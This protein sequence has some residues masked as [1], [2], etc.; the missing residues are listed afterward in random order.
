MGA[1]AYKVK[2]MDPWYALY[3]K[4]QDV[5]KIAKRAGILGAAVFCPRY[6]QISRRTDC[7]SFRTVEKYLFPNYLF[8]SFDI[9]TLH[10]SVL[11][12]IPGAVGFIRCGQSIC[13]V[14]Q[15]VISAIEAVHSITLDSES[16]SIDC[17]NISPELMIKIQKIIQIDSIEARQTALSHL[18]MKARH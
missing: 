1:L 2:I 10:T 6:H 12:A 4:V 14:S 9:N 11:S 13:T 3:C 17:R 5:D 8:L 16:D 15:E 7:S 18:V